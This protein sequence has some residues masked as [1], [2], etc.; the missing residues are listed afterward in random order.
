LCAGAGSGIS[1]SSMGAGP[2]G[3]FTRASIG[4]SSFECGLAG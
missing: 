4:L 3:V 1:R 2:W